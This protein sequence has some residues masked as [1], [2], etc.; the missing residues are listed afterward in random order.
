MRA[1]LADA[2]NRMALVAEGIM[3]ANG[4][5]R[6]DDGRCALCL[7]NPDE[8]DHDTDCPWRVARTSLAAS[9]LAEVRRLARV[10]RYER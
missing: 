4:P 10:L 7:V 5:G 8:G 1:N 6:T 9:D 3:S 2:L